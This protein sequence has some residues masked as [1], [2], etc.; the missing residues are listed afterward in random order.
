M[1]SVIRGRHSIFVT[2]LSGLGNQSRCDNL[3]RAFKISFMC[4]KSQLLSYC[5]DPDIFPQGT[6]AICH[7][8]E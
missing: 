1:I 7:C 5:K 2:D 8:W 3:L 6:L 4:K